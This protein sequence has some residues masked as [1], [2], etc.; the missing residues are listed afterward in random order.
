MMM[1][2]KNIKTFYLPPLPSHSQEMFTSMDE[3]KEHIDSMK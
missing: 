3:I 1:N 2:D